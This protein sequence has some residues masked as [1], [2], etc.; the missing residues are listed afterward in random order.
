[1][2]QNKHDEVSHLSQEEKIEY[3]NKLRRAV[4]NVRIAKAEL[5]GTC[6]DFDTSHLTQIERLMQFDIDWIIGKYFPCK[7]LGYGK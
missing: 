3:I 4:S 2:D 7:A 1:M 6:R 5:A